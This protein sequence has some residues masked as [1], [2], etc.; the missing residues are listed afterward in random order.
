MKIITHKSVFRRLPFGHINGVAKSQIFKVKNF[1]FRSICHELLIA[2]W[3]ERQTK[4]NHTLAVDEPVHVEPQIRSPFHAQTEGSNSN[5][6]AS[7]LQS[8]SRSVLWYVC[9][10]I[11]SSPPS[12][13][14]ALHARGCQSASRVS[15]FAAEIRD[16]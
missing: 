5:R 14:S 12:L 10:S 1:G 4:K 15:V 7:E 9:P 13:H 11:P 6:Y 3:T 2:E 8:H 16:V